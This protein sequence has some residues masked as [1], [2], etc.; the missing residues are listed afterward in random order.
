[1]FPYSSQR[2]YW[3]FSDESDLTMLREKTNADF[4]AKHGANMTVSL[5]FQ[6]YLFRTV[7]FSNNN[8]CVSI[9]VVFVIT[10]TKHCR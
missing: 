4:I 5:L 7:A 6:N 8:I 10:E 3:M 1:M 9:S 2:K